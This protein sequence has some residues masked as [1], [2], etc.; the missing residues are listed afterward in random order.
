MQRAA[1]RS[2]FCVFAISTF[3]APENMNTRAMDWL[4]CR[5]MRPQVQT[6]CGT[7]SEC[8]YA[9]SNERHINCA[10]VT[11]ITTT[12]LL[13]WS[14]SAPS[15]AIMFDK[16]WFH[17]HIYPADA[18]STIRQGSWPA[19]GSGSELSEGSRWLRRR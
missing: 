18:V 1:L 19:A 17:E 4:G 3:A 14:G 10:R 12:R 8:G 5:A 16:R 15:I 9:L 13:T 6:P 7:H 2:T 11:R